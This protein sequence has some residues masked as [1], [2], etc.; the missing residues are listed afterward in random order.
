[1]KIFFDLCPS[2]DSYTTETLKRFK[3]LIKRS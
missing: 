1:M 2:I 3:K